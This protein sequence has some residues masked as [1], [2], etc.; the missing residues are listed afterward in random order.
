MSEIIISAPVKAAIPVTSG[1][2]GRGLGPIAA[3]LA[4]LEVG[5]MV[6][7]EGATAGAI[8]S[9][10]TAAGKR[11]GKKFAVRKTNKVKDGAYVYGVWR[12]R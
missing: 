5:F 8:S 4:Q 7:I 12:T 3:A 6:E 9:A 11:D 10:A 1:G 2:A